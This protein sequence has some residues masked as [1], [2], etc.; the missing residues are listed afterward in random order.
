[1]LNVMTKAFASMANANAW[2][3]I[4]VKPAKFLQLGALDL[5]AQLN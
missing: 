1:M 2:I 5:M 3:C 4:V